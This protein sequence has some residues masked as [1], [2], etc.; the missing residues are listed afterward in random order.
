MQL[1]TVLLESHGALVRSFMLTV[2]QLLGS[3]YLLGA[4]AKQL[5]DLYE[6]E[7]KILEPWKEDSPAEVTA[8]DWRNFYGQRV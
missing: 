5:V 8:D 2:G 6:S 7:S 4:N 3:A 1:I